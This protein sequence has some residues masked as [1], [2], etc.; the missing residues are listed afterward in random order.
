MDEMAGAAIARPIDGAGRPT[1]LLPMAMLLQISIYWMGLSSIFG[2]LD[3][4]F[5]PEW[6]KGIA[7]PG[8]IATTTAL[9]SFMGALVAVV[10]QP[11]IGSISDYTMTRWGRRKPYLVIGATLDVVFIFALA[12]SY[13]VAA[14][15]VFTMLLQFSSNFAQGP[16]QGYVPDLVPARQVGLASA[17]VGV[18]SILG[19]VVGLGTVA[20]ALVFTPPGEKPDFQWPLLALGLFEL[21][22]AIVTVVTVDEGRK[23]RDRGGRPW[24]SVALEAWGREVFRYPSYLWMI[25]SRLLILAGI[26][27]ILKVADWYMERSLGLDL[28]ARGTWVL[29]IS[30]LIVAGVLISTFPAARL[31]DRVGRKPPIYAA[32]LIG[33]AG[34]TIMVIAPH[35]FVSAAGALIVGIAAGMFLAVDWALMTDIIPKAAAGKFMGFS[36][37]ATGL[38]GVFALASGGTLV[39]L[40]DGKVQGP[41][42]PRAAYGLAVGFFAVGALL[43]RQVDPTRLE[44]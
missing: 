31:S 32:C 16:F 22:T 24:L 8:R 25:G 17:L 26:G 36:N 41:V 28:G 34:M 19:N 3:A 20:L 7:E 35:V 11:T 23:P 18:M 27:M 43:L 29:I 38:A 37:L 1:A 21:G 14:I 44:D 12:N 4:L 39:D 30:G 42:G 9:I 6:L 15:I 33:A 2:G 5:L 10:V 40:I 13:T